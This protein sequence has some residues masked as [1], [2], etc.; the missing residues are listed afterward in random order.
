V[1][2]DWYNFARL[3]RNALMHDDVIRFDK[4]AQP[5]VSFMD[6]TIEAGD[7]GKHLSELG[8]RTT[9][10][11]TVLDSARAFVDNVLE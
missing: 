5:P 7:E 6:W 10:A 8:I 2:T 3:I 9:S 1:G 11:L 4:T